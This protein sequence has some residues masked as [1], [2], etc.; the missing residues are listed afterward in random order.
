LFSYQEFT[1]RNLGFVNAAEQ[2]R[3]R[4]STVF[5]PGVGGMGG[6]ALACL[7][8]SGV[9]NFIIADYDTFEVSNLNRQIFSDVN[10]LGQSKVLVAKEK[11]LQINPEIK[12]EVYD[13]DWVDQL[14]KVLKVASVVING[15]D[16]SLST[17]RLLRKAKEHNKTVIDAFA[18]S[19]PS[20]YVVRPQDPRPEEFMKFPTKKLSS[21]ELTPELARICAH[22]ETIYVLTHSSTVRHIKMEFAQEMISGKRKRISM[23]P[24]VWATGILMSYEAIKVLL[25][26]ESPISY[27]GVFLNPYDLKWEKPLG[28]LRAW[29]KENFIRWWLQRL[30]KG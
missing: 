26:Q 24:M 30:I 9:G 20:V 10:V 1:T 21:S 13:R 8:R 22:Q 15:C 11:I 28:F 18:A 27:K 25:H 19:I 16:D 23:A 7:A 14:D 2:S 12:V 4:A 17:V 3:L 5:I 29:I 6:M